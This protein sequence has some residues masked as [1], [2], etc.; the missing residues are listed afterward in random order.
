MTNADLR[1]LYDRVYRQ[2]EATFF[3]KFIDGA[4]ISET[5]AVMLAATTWEGKRVL[6][7]GCGTGKTSY[8]ISQAGAKRVVGIDFSSEAIKIAGER[9]SAENLSYQHM[10]ISG[11]KE[12]VDVV[13]SCGT[14]EH[15][16]KPRETL[17]AMGELVPY[18]GEVLIT[19]PYFLNIRGFIWMALQTLLKVPMSLSD[20]H[21]ISPFDIDDWLRGTPLTLRRVQTFDQSRANGELMLVDLRKRLA[22]ALRDARLDNSQVEA[23]VGWLTKVVS[24]REAVGTANLEGAT[25]L[26]VIQKSEV[27]PTS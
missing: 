15:T 7:A 2:G 17:L 3:S 26:Y 1:R 19:C 11:W 27:V 16:D 24:Y 4:N 6:D 12:P 20:L 21:F 5:D 22:N 25:A 18:G 13:I 10:E 9:F 23:F 8:L 14:L